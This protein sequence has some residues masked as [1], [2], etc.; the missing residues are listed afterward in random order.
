MSERRF[1]FEEMQGAQFREVDLSNARMHSMDL[2]GVKITDAWVFDVEISGLIG[3]LKVNDV[4][5]TAYVEAELNKR[6]PE[7]TRL[8]PTDPAGMR[9][10]WAM[11]SE[12][13]DQTMARARA[14]PEPKLDESVDGEYSFLQ[15]LR[16]LVMATDRWITGPVLGDPNPYH[17]L[18]M[19][20]FCR[21]EEAK[22]LGLDIDARPSFAEVV[23]AREDR[24]AK[25]AAVVEHLT[26]EEMLRQCPHPDRG[27]PTVQACLHVVLREEWAHNRYANRDLDALS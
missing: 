18:G 11:V 6:Y 14:L 8:A 13:W 27:T 5:V 24:R 25:V 21:P 22:A 20:P 26:L 2:S 9:D 10:S 23:A 3:G 4:D 12:L 1:E 7:R 17:P 15:T 16:H 19:P